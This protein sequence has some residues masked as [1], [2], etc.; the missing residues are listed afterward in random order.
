MHGKEEHIKV[1]PSYKK[2]VEGIMYAL[3]KTA[4]GV[5]T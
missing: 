5:E 2:P 3:L 1:R 4:L